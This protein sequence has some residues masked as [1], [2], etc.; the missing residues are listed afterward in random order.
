MLQDINKLRLKAKRLYSGRKLAAIESHLKAIES[1]LSNNESLLDLI[2]Q[3]SKKRSYIP[4]Y[5]LR[6]E[7]DGNFDEELLKLVKDMKVMLHGG[8][9][10]SMTNDQIRGS[11]MRKGQLKTSLSLRRK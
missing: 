9:P 3:H 11:Y 4:I 2:K 10:S 6:K 8:D 5:Q 7:F 1:L